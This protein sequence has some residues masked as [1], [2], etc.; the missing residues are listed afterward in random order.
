METDPSYLDLREEGYHF[1]SNGVMLGDNPRDPSVTWYSVTAPG[2]SQI[3]SCK[4][5]SAALQIARR[6]WQQQAP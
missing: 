4:G 1:I 2:G 5:I 6:H 3:G